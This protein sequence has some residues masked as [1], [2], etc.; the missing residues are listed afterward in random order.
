[1]ICI[2]AI[3]KVSRFLLASVASQ[4]G[5]NLSWLKISDDAFSHNVAQLLSEIFLKSVPSHE[6]SAV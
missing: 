3:S 5:L 1:M 6:R 4:A 2:L